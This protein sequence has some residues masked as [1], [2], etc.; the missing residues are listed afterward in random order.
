MLQ[1]REWVYIKYYRGSIISI[2]LLAT[3][4]EIYSSSD[5]MACLDYACHECIYGLWWVAIEMVHTDRF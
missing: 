4:L 5:E 2:S 1:K 3:C